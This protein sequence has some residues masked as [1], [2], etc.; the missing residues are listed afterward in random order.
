MA[1][2]G[3]VDTAVREK[4]HLHRSCANRKVRVPSTGAWDLA[5]DRRPQWTG[6]LRTLKVAPPD[7]TYDDKVGPLLAG[8]LN[9]C[10][11]WV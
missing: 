8:A 6:A 1:F 5:G 11:A 10:P 9:I 4:N 2:E 7:V 3:S